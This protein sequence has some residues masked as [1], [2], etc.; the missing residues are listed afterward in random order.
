MLPTMARVQLT[1]PLAAR[2]RR[3]LVVGVTGS[4]KTTLARELEARRGIPLVDV[5]ALAW[6]PGWVKTPD[7]Q[8]VAAVSTVVTGPQWV[9]DSAWGAIRPV[10]LE[11]V[12]LVV[13]LD[14]PRH[15]SFTRLA[16]RTATRLVTRERI[17]GDNVE[18]WR[19]TFSPSSIL[20]WHARSFA[21]KRRLVRAW[22]ADPDLPPVLRLTTP[23]EVRAFLALA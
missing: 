14:L 1:D 10:V 12:D 5:D 4:G 15:V 18:S 6:Q 16:R 3:V 20:V 13:G 23:A 11:H 7:A 17:C 2:A 8:L 22:E 21:S 9:L 19:Q